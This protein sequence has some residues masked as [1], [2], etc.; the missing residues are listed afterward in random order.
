VPSHW[1]KCKL[2]ASGGNCGN[3]GK[4]RDSI[5][6]YIV[7]C[8][9]VSTLGARGASA[10]V[11]VRDG[12]RVGACVGGAPAL[13]NQYPRLRESSPLGRKAQQSKQQDNKYTHTQGEL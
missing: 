7:G 4:C 6:K 3:K 2:F 5:Q 12:D 11:G 13:G 9:K 1:S 10:V 8:R